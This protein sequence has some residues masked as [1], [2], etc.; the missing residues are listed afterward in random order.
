MGELSLYHLKTFYTVARHLNYSRAGEELAISQPAVSRQVAALE[1]NL[2]MDLFV[3]RG[4]KVELTDAGR[5]LFDYVDRIF[6]LVDRAERTLAEYKDLERGKVFFGAG[7]TIGGR[8]IPQILKS[9][10]QMHP[11]IE[12]SLLLANSSTIERMVA[13]GDLDLG[14]T[15]GSVMDSALHMESV[16]REELVPV[17]SAQHP[18]A[19]PDITLAELNG[20]MLLWRENGSAARDVV[21]Q[22]LE[23][24][25]LTFKNRAEIRDSG[26]IKQLVL[27][28]L[29]VAFLPRRAVE[30]ELKSGILHRIACSDSAIALNCH[31]VSAKD[32]HSYPAVLAF[33]NYVRK[34]ASEHKSKRS[35]GK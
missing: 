14:F 19:R 5:S 15:A 27:E 11:R 26:A 17:I 8:L 4:R 1:K 3:Q 32:M 30:R 31:I 16:F 35:K 9:F 13:C 28:Q 12:V 21:E 18:L 34:W 33:L 22:Y 20:E 24:E 29:G 6:H 10:R 25:G 7:I 2:G 23:E